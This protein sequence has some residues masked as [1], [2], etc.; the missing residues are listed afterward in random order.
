MMQTLCW[1]SKATGQERVWRMAGAKSKGVMN[2]KNEAAKLLQQFSGTPRFGKRRLHLR[3]S[4]TERPAHWQMLCKIG[5]TDAPFSVSE[6]STRGGISSYD[7]RST[8]PLAMSPSIL[9]T[10]VSSDDRCALCEDE[11]PTYKLLHV[12]THRV[13]THPNCVAYGCIACMTL[14]RLA[15]FYVEQITVSSRYQICE[16]RPETERRKG[17]VT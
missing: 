14:I 4:L 12:L 8:M 15:V 7:L 17:V 1:P 13:A 5:T 6:Y 11:P 3:A 16:E 2:A 9:R 10:P